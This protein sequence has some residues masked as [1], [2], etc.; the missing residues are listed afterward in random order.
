MLQSIPKKWR[1]SREATTRVVPLP[2]KGSRIRLLS[3]EP[4]NKQVST[5][6][7]GNTAKC[8]PLY[9][10]SGI[11]QTDRLFLPRGWNA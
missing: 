5:N 8:T 4:A 6:F 9:L 11:D 1:F 3:L 7:S 10:E 2:Q